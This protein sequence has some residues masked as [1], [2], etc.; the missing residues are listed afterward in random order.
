[1]K[2]EILRLPG[3]FRARI[4][5]I[6]AARGRVPVVHHASAGRAIVRRVSARVGEAR[7]GPSRR[8][9]QLSVTRARSDWMKNRRPFGR[10]VSFALLLLVAAETLILARDV[11]KRE[12]P[13][14]GSFMPSGRGC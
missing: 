14:G 12:V 4:R 13:P 11:T 10:R 9:W 3:E 7:E 6:R 5:G 8:N 1:M 2:R